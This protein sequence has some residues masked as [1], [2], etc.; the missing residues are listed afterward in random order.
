LA[1]ASGKLNT[2]TLSL[3]STCPASNQKGAG[4]WQEGVVG[5]QGLAG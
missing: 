3:P 5:Q 4:Q 1:G 2:I